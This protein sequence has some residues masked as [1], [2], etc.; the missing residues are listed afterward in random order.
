MAK[1]NEWRD[2]VGVVYSTS[3]EFDYRTGLPAEPETLKPGAQ[4]LLV[5]LDRSGR[6]GK[7]VTLITGF[8]GKVQDLEALAKQLKSKCGTGGSVKNNEILIQGD[9][10]ARVREFL[11][12]LGYSAKVS[13]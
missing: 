6:A 13:G 11:K 5:Q 12:N 2:R 8:V 9:V 10:R 7:T 1:K 3:T 4:R